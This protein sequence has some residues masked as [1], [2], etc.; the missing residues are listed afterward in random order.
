[1][2][3]RTFTTTSPLTL[4]CCSTAVAVLL[5]YLQ[6]T[7]KKKYNNKS[8]SNSEVKDES[9]AYQPQ[10]Q[11]QPQQQ[12][13]GIHFEE[14]PYYF[15]FLESVKG[16]VRMGVKKLDEDTWIEIGTTY[17][18]QMQLKKKI[19]QEQRSDVIIYILIEVFSECYY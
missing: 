18:K 6:S 4:I 10:S 1:M 12:E 13:E 17:L 5:Y 19:L 15:P 11:P 3:S 14:E 2:F 8:I 7:K 16:K 9:N